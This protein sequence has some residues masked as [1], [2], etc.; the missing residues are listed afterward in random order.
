MY[1]RDSDGDYHKC[2][3]LLPDIRRI[4]G[5]IEYLNGEPVEIIPEK[6]RVRK[7]FSKSN[8][9]ANDGAGKKV[10]IDFLRS[11]G[12]DAMENPNDY[13]IDLMVAKYEVERRT[14]YTNKWP[15]KTVH[16][17]EREKRNSLS[18]IYTML[19]SCTMRQRQKPLIRYYSVRLM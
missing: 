3:K 11:R 18:I 10:V 9:N 12:I 15:Y 5:E 17:P 4:F 7:P 8:H 6:E 1:F 14:I 13:G 2:H 19:L 16:V